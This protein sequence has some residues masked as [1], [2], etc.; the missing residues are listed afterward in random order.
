MFNRSGTNWRS[1]KNQRFTT[2]LTFVGTLLSGGLLLQ[3]NPAEACDLCAVYTARN[4]KESQGGTFSAGAFEQFTS[5]NSL[6]NDG[7]H[8]PNTLHQSM[9]SSITQVFGR[10]D[11]T[12]EAAIQ[13]NAPFISRDF[14]RAEGGIL[15]SGNESGI[16]DIS[17]IGIYSPLKIQDGETSFRISLRGG[18]KLPTGDASRLREET[19]EGH[20]EET[21]TEIMPEDTATDEMADMAG[22]EESADHHHSGRLDPKHG[23]HSHDENPSGIHGHDLALGS[24]S[25]DYLVG[26]TAMAE[27]GLN[28]ALAD[29]Q[30]SI[31]TEGDFD[32]RYQNDLTYGL[33]AGR[34]LYAG[35]EAT[36][37][38]QAA[39]SGEYK[40]MDVYAGNKSSDT[41]VNSMFA[42]PEL[43]ITIGESL[44]GLLAFDLPLFIDNTELQAVPDYRLRAAFSW[45]F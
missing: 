44:S 18:L 21:A 14:K 42:G 3:A 32:Y 4:I 28:F 37:S 31:R 8:V 40:G 25:V 36:V 29:L 9:R 16:G 23:G 17:L 27:Y 24:G 26:A 39:L 12:N 33:S 13:I 10:Y 1:M 15:Q 2:S 22:T 7:K 19:E 41:G 34:Y 20:E 38:L 43:G 6:Q 45:H 30:F 11:L 35:H 5:F